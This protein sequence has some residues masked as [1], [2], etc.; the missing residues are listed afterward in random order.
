MNLDIDDITR[1]EEFARSILHQFGHAL[2]MVHEHQSP[3]SNI[4]WDEEKVYNYYRAHYNWNRKAV[5]SNIL[6]Q[7]DVTEAN[8]IEFDPD[9]IMMYEIPGHLTK[10]HLT[11]GGQ[12]C[13][14]SE[15]DKL[16]IAKWYPGVASMP[17]AIPRLSA[18]PISTGQRYIIMNIE[19]GNVAVLEDEL[20]EK[21][22]TAKYEQNVAAE[23]VSRMSYAFAPYVVTD[24][25]AGRKWVITKL[26]SGFYTIKNVAHETYASIVMGEPEIK[27]IDKVNFWK[28]HKTRYVGEYLYVSAHSINASVQY[29]FNDFFFSRSITSTDG[30]SFWELTSEEVDAQVRG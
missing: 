1:E 22:L 8:S 16:L 10:N 19:H 23:Q 3:A 20:H 18:E 6:R 30:K 28:I 12:N 17:M 11:V 9:S 5:Y 27:A 13:K 15:K 4:P 21:T 26:S 14:L 2:G 24:M 25:I 29:M 7:Y